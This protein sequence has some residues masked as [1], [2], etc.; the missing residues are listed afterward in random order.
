[1]AAAGSLEA[2]AHIDPH[3]Y[4]RLVVQ[5]AP[6]PE[7]L[8]IPGEISILQS[9]MLT[10]LMSSQW[11]GRG[12]VLEIG[13]LFGRSTQA[14][15][16]GMAANP[17]RQGRYIAADFFGLYFPSHTTEE[18]LAPLLGHVPV[19]RDIV[20]AIRAGSFQLAFE[21][22]HG[23]GRPYSSFLSVRRC[24]VQSQS[25]ESNELHGL[26]AE[27]SPIGVLF[28]DSAKAYSVLRADSR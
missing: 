23:T 16:L 10:H 2:L 13:T 9:R 22:L 20:A 19:W 28:V 4:G 14:I 6:P 17:R 3:L 18:R 7:E 21:T 27:A 15:G 5:L 24:L 8:A 26:I 11:D 25:S 1:L 12:N